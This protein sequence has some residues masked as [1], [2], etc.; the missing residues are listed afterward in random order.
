MNKVAGL[1]RVSSFNGDRFTLE[2]FDNR[3]TEKQ[4]NEIPYAFQLED[5]HDLQH[6]ISRLIANS[7]N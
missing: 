1:F 2:W 5:A 4:W 3:G 7:D 6:V